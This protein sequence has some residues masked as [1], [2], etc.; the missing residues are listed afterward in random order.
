VVQRRDDKGIGMAYKIISPPPIF[1]NNI[2]A[3]L[4]R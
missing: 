1:P 4:I 3:V 2:G